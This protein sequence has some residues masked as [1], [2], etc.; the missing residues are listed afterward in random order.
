MSIPVILA[1]KL[2]NSGYD[3]DFALPWG[4]GHCGDYDL[5]ELFAWIDH[6]CINDYDFDAATEK[7][8]KYSGI[9]K[10]VTIPNMIRGVS[11]TCIGQG[12][13]YGCELNSVTIPDSVTSLEVGAFSGCALSKAVFLGDQP[14]FTV[15]DIF[16]E[17]KDDFKIIVSSTAAGFGN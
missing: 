5:D 15:P 2:I 3:V 6:I 10:D 1:A 14:S 4:V 11:V 7:I 9:C 13:F 17:A 12:A 16:P 8:K